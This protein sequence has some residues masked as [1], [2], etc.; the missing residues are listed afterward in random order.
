MSSMSA[1]ERMRRY[2]KRRRQGLQSVRLDLHV[3][4]IDDLIRLGLLKEEERQNP[5]Q[6]QSAVQ[7]LVYGALEGRGMIS[8]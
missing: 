6:V 7:S 5:E 1:A 4:D 3:T 8:E 2:R